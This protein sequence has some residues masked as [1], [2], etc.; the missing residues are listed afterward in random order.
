MKGETRPWQSLQVFWTKQ[1]SKLKQT[2]GFC[3]FL[4]THMETISDPILCFQHTA[5]IVHFLPPPSLSQL[6]SCLGR[7][8]VMAPS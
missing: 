6:L 8:A 1:D 2:F 3:S 7:D 4:V 5:C